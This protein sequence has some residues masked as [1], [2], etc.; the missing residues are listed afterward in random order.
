MGDL[1][2]KLF[3]RNKDGAFVEYKEPYATVECETE[4][5]FNQIQEAVRQYKGWI[6]VEEELPAAG[7]YILISFYNFSIPQIGRYEEDADGG[8]AFY[9]GDEAET[10]LTQDLIVNA[11]MELPKPYKE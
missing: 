8:G 5:D 1:D 10:C 2:T 6:P 7:K 11:W 4:E 3:V 9:I